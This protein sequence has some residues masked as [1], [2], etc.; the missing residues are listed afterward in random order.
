MKA[1]VDRVICHAGE[2]YRLEIGQ[3]VPAMPDALREI[4]I[5]SGYL[6]APAEKPAA[7]KPKEG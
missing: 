3:D 7:R 2:E 4:L 1:R 6:E 5:K